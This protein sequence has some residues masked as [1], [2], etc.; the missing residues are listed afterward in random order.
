MKNIEYF[1]NCTGV[2]P[3][4]GEGAYSVCCG[5]DEYLDATYVGQYKQKMKEIIEKFDNENIISVRSSFDVRN[6]YLIETDEFIWVFNDSLVNRIKLFDGIADCSNFK[7]GRY[8]THFSKDKSEQ[9]M[10]I[11]ELRAL[12]KLSQRDF[13]D[14]YNIPRRTIENWES[15][16]TKCPDYVVELLEFRVKHDVKVGIYG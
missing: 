14:R 10:S 15:E 13:A 3:N 2:V 1:T 9:H 4:G 12:T 8:V 7:L 11:K 16:T 5:I 6:I